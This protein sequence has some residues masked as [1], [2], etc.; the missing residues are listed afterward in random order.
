MDLDGQC[1]V[2]PTDGVFCQGL[3]VEGCK[4]DWHKHVLG[5]SDPK[6]LFTPMPIIWM[7]PMNVTEFKDFQ[8]YLCP[9]YKTAERRGVLSTTGHST[10]FVM[11]VRLPSDVP[12]SHWVKRGV[13]ML[14]SL[15]E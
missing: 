15:S 11:D 14:T 6:V 4:W 5:E 9:V 1:Q 12:A 8:H 7:I 10:N 2:A 3:F 13:A